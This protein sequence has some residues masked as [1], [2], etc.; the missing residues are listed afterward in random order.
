MTADGFWAEHYRTG[1]LHYFAS[2]GKKAVC[3]MHDDTWFPEG[4]L[5]HRGGRKA[6]KCKRCEAHVEKLNAKD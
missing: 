6:T 4:Y 3:G 1:R 2:E 5:K